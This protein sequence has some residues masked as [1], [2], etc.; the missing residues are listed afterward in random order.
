MPVFDIPGFGRLDLEH[1]VLD[2]NGTIAIDGV[3]IPGVANRM[4]ALAESFT[5]HVATADTHGTARAMLAGL[6]CAVTLLGPGPED[7]SKQRIIHELGAA[8]TA[9]VGN[10]R[11]D[12]LA[13][14]DAALGIAVI[15][16]ECAAAGAVAASDI[17]APDILMA[18]EL[19]RHPKRLIATL[20][21]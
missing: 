20:R 2:C 6:P 16:S 5:I 12:R 8:R 7:V 11:N 13:L 3:L 14:A 10:G 19:F 1:L 15:Q 21:T 4:A 9:F 18:L 17:V